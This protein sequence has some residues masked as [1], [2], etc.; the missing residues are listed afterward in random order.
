VVESAREQGAGHVCE[1]GPAEGAVTAVV[2][3]ARPGDT[4]LTLGAGDVWKLGDEVLRRLGAGVPAG[5]K[6]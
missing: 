5:G 1:A 2:A 4:V 3:E 6:V